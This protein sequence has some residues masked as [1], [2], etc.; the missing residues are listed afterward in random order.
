MDY[1]NLGTSGLK[2]SRIALGG[3]SFGTP[4]EVMPWTLDEDA[5]QPIFRQALDL[6]I[7]FWDTANAYGAGT[8]E[9]IVGRAIKQLTTREGIVLATKIFMPMH[10]GPGGRWPL[11]QSDPRTGR[12]VARAPGHRLRRPAPDP[13]L[14]PR[15]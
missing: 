15:R 4:R 11:T 5:S 2:V 3:M 13:P 12:R 8:S 9:E 14:R 6:G 10:Q 7:T 1:T